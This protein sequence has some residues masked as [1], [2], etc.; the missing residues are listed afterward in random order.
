MLL[1]VAIQMST[2]ITDHVVHVMHR[3]TRQRSQCNTSYVVLSLLSTNM[4]ATSTGDR[5]TTQYQQHSNT[6]NRSNTEST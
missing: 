4:P 5:T 2:E 3:Q 1:A 6:V